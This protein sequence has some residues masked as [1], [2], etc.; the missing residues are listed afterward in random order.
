MNDLL[1]PLSFFSRP[2]MQ[3]SRGK[4][5]IYKR[6]EVFSR[7]YLQINSNEAIS[8]LCSSPPTTT[9]FGR[10]PG[11]TEFLAG[12]GPVPSISAAK[13]NNKV[14]GTH[15]NLVRRQE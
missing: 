2:G 7:T 1:V 8:G 14:C 4:K 11:G 5:E 12:L 10:L 9:P 3:I 13:G 6:C 15:S